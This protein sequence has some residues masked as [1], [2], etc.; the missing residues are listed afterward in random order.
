MIVMMVGVLTIIV[1]LVMRFRATPPPLP[2]TITMPDGA[3]AVSFTQGD[4]WYAVITDEDEILIF[5]RVTGQLR[6]TVQLFQD[7]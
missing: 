3:R 4:N 1:L 6:Q 7:K 2:A 5:D